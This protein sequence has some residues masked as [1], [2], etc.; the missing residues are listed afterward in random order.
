MGSRV[1]LSS[2]VCEYLRKLQPQYQ[3][4]LAQSQ[5]DIDTAAARGDLRENR[6][7]ELAKQ[8]FE[9]KR[10]QLQ[11]LNTV[12]NNSEE[13]NEV[14]SSINRVEVMTKVVF[15]HMDTGK[16]E[17]AYV[18]IDTLGDVGE[19]DDSGNQI[20]PDKISSESPFGSMLI[21]KQ[22]GSIITFRGKRFKIKSIELIDYGAFF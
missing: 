17:E 13:V 1:K 20:T 11:Q 14:R 22:V 2:E 8:Q 9:L 6:E 18:V 16:D 12:I 7:F 5:E 19:L 21:G 10:Q 3:S 4:E 15:T